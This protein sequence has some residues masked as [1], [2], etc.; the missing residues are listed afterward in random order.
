MTLKQAKEKMIVTSLALFGLVGFAFLP[1]DE[2][3]NSAGEIGWAIYFVI[4]GMFFILTVRAFLDYSDL[5]L[6]KFKRDELLKTLQEEHDIVY[7]GDES[8]PYDWAKEV[9]NP[10]YEEEENE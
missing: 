3:S 4:V 9:A 7:L 5:R 10:W 6:A 2:H 8:E 1:P